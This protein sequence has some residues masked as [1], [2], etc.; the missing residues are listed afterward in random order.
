MKALHRSVLRFRPETRDRLDELAEL[1]SNVLHREVPRAAV[2]RAVVCA[3]LA[4]TEHAD[5]RLLVEAIRTS[6]VPRGKK[7]PK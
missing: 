4:T 6:I 1:A 7:K 5:P 2:V 3:W